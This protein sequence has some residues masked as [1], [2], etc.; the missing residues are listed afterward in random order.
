MAGSQKRA[1]KAEKTKKEDDDGAVSMSEDEEPKPVRK[2][3]KYPKVHG[4]LVHF[5]GTPSAKEEKAEMRELN[6]IV[7]DVPQYLDWSEKPIT[8]D[9]DDHPDHVPHPGKYA[10]VVDPI[11]DNFRLTKVLM[12]GGSSLNIIYADTLKRMNLSES[13]LDYSKVKFHG[14]V[15]GKQAKSMGSIRLEVT[16]G[17]ETNYRSEYLRFEVVPFKSAYH[18]I[19]GRPAFAKFMARP[20]YIYSKLK[21]PGPNGTITISGNFKKAKECERGNAAF[22]EAVLHAE[23]LAMLKKELDTSQLPEHVKTAEQKNTF[24]ASED[25]KKAD[26]VPGDSSKQVTIGAGLDDK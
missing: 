1:K 13:Q 17:P 12:D 7:P 5:L 2:E 16:F 25:T 19:F 21:M 6:A 10:L 15:P 23:E 26:L 20:C 9:R 3:R 4:Q 8:W 18:A 24:K 14:I 22:A 11:V